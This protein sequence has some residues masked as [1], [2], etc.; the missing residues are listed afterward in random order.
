MRRV[1]RPVVAIMALVLSVMPAAAVSA[2]GDGRIRPADRVRGST[3]GELLGEWWAKVAA[4]PLG[5]NPFEGLGERCLT[6]GRKGG[7]LGPVTGPTTCT[8]ESGT[9]VL[10][11]GFTT[12]CSDVE[13]PPAFAEGEEAQQAC[14]REENQGRAEAT[15]VTLDGGKPVNLQSARFELVSP[16]MTIQLPENNLFGVPA[17]QATFAAHAWAAVIRGL[18]RGQH[19][20]GMQFVGNGSTTLTLNVVKRRRG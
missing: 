2:N 4:Q 8:V 17:Q 13:P 7:V 10:L 16:Q 5:Q 12:E 19:V 1:W 3:G 18:S 9:P 11:I 6:L 20:V 14:A 15:L